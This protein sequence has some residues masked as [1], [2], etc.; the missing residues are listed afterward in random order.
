LNIL[1]AAM[2]RSFKLLK[3][4]DGKFKEMGTEGYGLRKITPAE[5]RRKFE[6]LTEDDLLDMVQEK[7]YEDTEKW[8]KK[9]MGGDNGNYQ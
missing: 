7:G 5:D 1:T 3:N 6:N 4:V 8:L 2:E 9:H